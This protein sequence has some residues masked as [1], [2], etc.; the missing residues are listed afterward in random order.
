MF[1]ECIIVDKTPY[2]MNDKRPTERIRFY[3]H[4][5]AII[6]CKCVGLS[7]G[8]LFVHSLDLY[9][10]QRIFT[11]PLRIIYDREHVFIVYPFS[12][13]DAFELAQSSFWMIYEHI[14]LSVMEQLIEHLNLFH[15]RFS[16]A[17]GDIKPENI[18][19]NNFT[20]I[21]QYIDLEYATAPGIKPPST[22]NLDIASLSIH[23]PDPR[24][25]YY[26]TMTT[27]GYTSFQKRCGGDYCVFENDQ[28]ALATT[29]FCLLTNRRPPGLSVGPHIL[30]EG[31]DKS[32]WDRLHETTFDELVTHVDNVLRWS[33]ANTNSILMFIRDKWLIS[34]PP[35]LTA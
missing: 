7:S 27:V 1:P 8:E 31:S 34:G 5:K 26:K 28:Y 4:N 29:L 20:G 13:T 32:K 33:K 19:Y 22:Q 2:C 15:T 30:S 6:V 3:E 35:L 21:V 24:T 9:R 17:M 25:R 16:M 23:V 12:G 10:D 14:T 11:K 18:V